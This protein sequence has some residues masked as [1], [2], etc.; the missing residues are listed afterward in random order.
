[1]KHGTS[2]LY[3]CPP[4]GKQIRVDKHNG[5]SEAIVALALRATCQFSRLRRR[6]NIL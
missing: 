1:M 5:H 3:T 4:C 6:S 2:M